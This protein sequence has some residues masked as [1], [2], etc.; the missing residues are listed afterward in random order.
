MFGLDLMDVEQGEA[1][2]VDQD[3][4]MQLDED[5]EVAEDEATDDSETYLLQVTDTS[6]LWD[7]FMDLL[8]QEIRSGDAFICIYS[9]TDLASYNCID[10]YVRKIS[11][12]LHSFCW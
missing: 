5:E 1:L 10:Y 12:K 3:E 4:V 11:M 7:V 6:G 9:A 8:E 2:D